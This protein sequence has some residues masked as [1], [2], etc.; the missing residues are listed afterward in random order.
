MIRNAVSGDLVRSVRS[1]NG[2]VRT[3]AFDGAGQK[4]AAAG[5]WTTRVWDLSRPAEPPEDVGGPEGTTE[6]QLR[7]DG[8]AVA[9]CNGT[10]GL[11]RLW[12]LAA[13][14]RVG[15]QNIGSGGVMG[16][17][18]SSATGELLVAG[19]EGGVSSWQARPSQLRRFAEDPREVSALGI[20]ESGRWFATTGPAGTAA[21]WDAVDGRHLADVADV[22]ASRAVVFAAA[23]R[24]VFVGDS[25]GQLV[26]WDWT[27]GS[28]RNLRRISSSDKEIL[29]LAAQGRRLIVAHRNRLV[30]VRDS[31]DARELRRLQLSAAPFSIA[32]A[33]DGHTLAV[34]TYNG[35][36]EIWNAET[37][38]PL[39]TLKGPTQLV[40]GLQFSPDGSLLAAS[41]RDGSTRLWDVASQRELATIASRRAGA[42]R[43]QFLQSGR[44][45]AIGYRDGEL[46]VWD[47]DYFFR[48]AA[49]NADYQLGLF[50]KAGEIFPRAGEALAWSRRVLEKR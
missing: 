25:A 46:E 8:R 15:H 32:T 42:E 9:T 40:G 48:Y 30:V 21:L 41:S 23:D 50:R 43:L 1:E 45:L 36:V 4:L 14:A 16:L 28:V 3:L 39:A 34:G 10:N 2:R 7:P 49:G 26:G 19:S 35:D 33:P 20:S 47:L 29:A 11:V 5:E 44:R 38:T 6:A 17:G 37:G 31:E 18:V 22:G 27:E 13:D 12:Y 24:R